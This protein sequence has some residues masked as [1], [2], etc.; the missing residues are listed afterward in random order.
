MVVTQTVSQ[1][2]HT[3]VLSRV[4]GGQSLFFLGHSFLLWYPGRLDLIASKLPHLPILNIMMLRLR[5]KYGWHR[6]LNGQ[7]FEN[8]LGNGEGQESLVCCSSWGRKE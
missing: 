7:E 5:R 1:E 8:T 3:V 4:N 2:T 6:Q